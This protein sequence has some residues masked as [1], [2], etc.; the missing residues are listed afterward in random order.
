LALGAGPGRAATVAETRDF[1]VLV[2]GKHAGD[3][4][5]TITK[6]DDGTVTMQCDTDVKVSV[7]LATVKYS[8]R[9]YEVWKDGK[10]ARFN[11]TCDDNGKGY[12]VKA[13]PDGDKL[14]VTVEKQ[15]RG[16]RNR[17]ERAV[18]G[19]VWLTSYWAQPDNK[20]INR[21]IPLLD[22]DT[23]KNLEGK[24]QYV[25]TES[26]GVAG[27]TVNVNHFRLTGKVNVDL[28]YD[29]SGRL[30]RQEW[31]EEGHRMVVELTRLRR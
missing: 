29:G 9:G 10:L 1:A 12:S 2:D 22:S 23:G 15:E 28:W 6:S 21:V 13:V 14:K 7:L 30:V 20:W 4:H 8:Y 27:Q 5:M 18:R 17:E 3:A 31:L 11:S 25:A 24:F 19:D 16:A 26:R